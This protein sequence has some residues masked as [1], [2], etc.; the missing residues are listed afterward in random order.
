MPKCIYE[1]R[2]IL[3]YAFHSLIKGFA[4]L[5]D[6]YWIKNMLQENKAIIKLRDYT[7]QR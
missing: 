3:A 2:P 1:F 5:M 6:K 7:A 4:V